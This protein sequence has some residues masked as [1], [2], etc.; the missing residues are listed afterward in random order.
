MKKVI[1]FAPICEWNDYVSF[2]SFLH[3]EKYKYKEV[4][5]VVPPKAKHIIT[6][7]DSY[8][9]ISQDYFDNIKSANS[10]EIQGS[11]NRVIL[12]KGQYIPIHS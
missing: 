5:V 7:A 9:T 8:I 10:L 2:N 3:K 6:E 11:T 4:C 1:Y 12:Y